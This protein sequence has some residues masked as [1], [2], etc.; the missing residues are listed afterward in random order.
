MTKERGEKNG[1]GGVRGNREKLDQEGKRKEP[2]G[3]RWGR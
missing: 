3:V 1:E 2:D